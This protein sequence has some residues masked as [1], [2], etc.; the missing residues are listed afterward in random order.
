MSGICGICAPGRTIDSCALES[1]T[2][3]LTLLG[4][5]RKGSTAVNFAAFGVAQR[6]DS[7]DVATVDWVQIAVDAD[8][9]NLAELKSILTQHGYASNEW[10]VAQC[11]ARLYILKG[12]DFLQHLN[13]VFSLALWDG[14]SQ[15]LLLA[16]D[17]LGVK[18]LYWTREGDRLL[19][20]SRLGALRAV[21]EAPSEL[22]APALTQFLIFSVIPHPLTIYRG[23]EKL[24]PGTRL[25]F[26]NGT[27]K[28]ER[29][30]SLSYVESADHNV[31]SWAKR[32][33]EQMRVSV[34]RHLRDATPEKT[35]A[36]LS[37]GTDS[38][39]VVAFMNER[40]SPVNTFS[41][42]FSEATYSE[43]SFARTTANHFRTHHHERL[44]GPQDALEALTQITQYYDE[45]FA[46]SS[47]FGA[48]YCAVLA[49]ESG[50]DLLLAGDGGDE[51]FAGN[52]RYAE[53]RK[54]GLYHELPS[55][56][57]K[58]LIEP[59]TG[60]LP[61]NDGWLSLPR[62]YVRRA[63][64]PNPRRIFSYNLFLSTD[65]SEIF[66]AGFLAQAPPEAWLDIANE[67]YHAAQAHSELNRL[68]H[69]DVKMTLADNDLRKVSGTAEIVGVRVRYPLLDYPLAELSAQIPSKLKMKGFQ[70]RYIFKR[71]MQSI[72]PHEVLYKKKHGFGVPL[73]L[74][75][76]K[77]RNLNALMNDVL[78]DPRTKQRGY[79]RKGF[80]DSIL[81][82]HREG[83]AGF[84]GEILWYLVSLELWHRKHFDIHAVAQNAR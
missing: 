3:A 66:E 77:D 33:Q 19:F 64:I 26:E 47:A 6:W 16:I 61:A 23:I 35:G 78:G 48:Y 11:L 34:H 67:H 9:Y 49:R 39:S 82:N 79:F 56:I 29:Y 80:Y 63:S 22:S 8:L 30:W 46:N 4:E 42:V 14:K 52:S 74:W 68:L 24:A 73:G 60:L 69:L 55:W 32:L 20:A 38:S 10:T 28:Q 62:K 53:D 45:P 72:L 44:L 50:I 18:G 27:V 25:L 12:A 71:A 54:F 43:A 13:G 7:Q 5:A 41:M 37:G 1:M 17:R 57:R 36:Y 51:L 31:S 81:R 84:Y 2:E 58:G 70:K 65:P 76:L 40:F 59:A 83:H 21:Q 15:R 75:L